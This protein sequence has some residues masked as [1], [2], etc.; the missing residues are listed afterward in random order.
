MKAFYE[1]GFRYA[2]MPWDI[3][4]RAE[5]MELVES[6]RLEPCRDVDAAIIPTAPNP[7]LLKRPEIHGRKGG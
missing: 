6:G 3:G 7:P 1:L 2:R 5:L 4:P